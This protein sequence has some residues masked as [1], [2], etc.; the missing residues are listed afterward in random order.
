MF[1]KIIALIALNAGVF[2]PATALGSMS[3]ASYSI[4]ADIIGPNGLVYASGTTFSLTDTAGEAVAGTIT[5]GSYTLRGGFQSSEPDETLSF[6]VS[7]SSVALG[8]LSA[9]SVASADT[10]LTVTCNAI[11]G[12]TLSVSSAS[13]S[14]PTVVS[15]G[16]VTAGSEEYGLA[17]AG[18]DKAFSNDASVISGRVLASSGVPVISSQTTAIFKAAMSSAST[19]GTY[20]QTVTLTA[21][22]NF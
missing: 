9:S 4:S 20:S 8:T 15:D 6:T 22:A 21:S 19:A 14:M 17:V 11:T 10:V 12:Y 18:T 7:A 3:S 16:S 1:K 5:S 13:G 2:F